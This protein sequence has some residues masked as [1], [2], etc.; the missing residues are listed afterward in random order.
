MKYKIVLAMLLASAFSQTTIANSVTGKKYAH[1]V[2]SYTVS[3]P[4]DQYAKT[5]YPIIFAHGMAGFIRVGTDSLGLD[6]WYQIVPSIAR[7]GG[8]VWAARMSPFNTPEVRGEQLIHQVEEVRAITGAA[9]VNLIGHSHGG[10]TIRY[11]AGVTPHQVASLTSIAGNNQ[12]SPIA[13]LIL[14]TENIPLVGSTIIAAVTVLSKSIIF[15]QQL[16][17]NEFP[18][19]AL[20][21]GRSIT[22]AETAK[23]NKV[24]PAGVSKGRCGEG[25]YYENGIYNYSFMGIGQLTNILD[26]DSIMGVTGKLIRDDQS[27]GLVPRCSAKFGKTIRDDY[28][29]NH[30]DEVNQILGLKSIFAPDPVSVYT[31]HANRLKLQGL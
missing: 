23:F 14:S 1:H 7:R 29:W 30:L 8:N 11:V 12:G 22:L 10:P 20:E 16:N 27:D 25:N 13:D 26:A 17:P 4:V 6:Y 5:K 24:F 9:K 19:N 2:K 15:A 21:S 31:Q 3:K 18:H 28:N